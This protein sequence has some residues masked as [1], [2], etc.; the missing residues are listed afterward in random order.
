M[1]VRWVSVENSRTGLYVDFIDTVFNFSIYPYTDRDIFDSKDAS[2]LTERAFN[3]FNVDYRQA[4]IGS[5]LA[6]ID[7][8]DDDLV[9]DRNYHFRVHLRPYLLSEYNPYDFCRV[10]YPNVATSVLPMP[11]VSRIWT[12]LTSR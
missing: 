3:T 9:S 11:V 6:G 2:S 4:A 8:S 12:A 1:G 10:E 5:S 7:V